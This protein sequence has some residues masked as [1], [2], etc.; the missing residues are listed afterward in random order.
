MHTIT[1]F[2]KPECSLCDAAWYV[3]DR[4]RRQIA[5]EVER[6][7]ITAVGCETWLAAYCHDIPVVHLDGVEIFRHRVDER[8]LRELLSI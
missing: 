6:V 4:V 2:A 8:R 1:F 5:F 7:D 3:I